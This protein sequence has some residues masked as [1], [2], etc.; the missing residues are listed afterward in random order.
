[1]FYRKLLAALALG[2]LA[3]GLV[4]AVRHPAGG[5]FPLSFPKSSL[6]ARGNPAAPVRV[7]EYLDY[8]CPACVAQSRL[9]EGYAA[10][11]PTR[12]YWEVRFYPFLNHPHAFKSAIYADCAARR[13][14]FWEFHK[15]LFE[16]QAEW[17]ALPRERIDDHLEGL[18]REVGIAPEAMRACVEDPR[19]KEA[20][21]EEVSAAKAAGVRVTP[22]FLV[23]GKWVTTEEDL[24][25][26][27]ER[28]LA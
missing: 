25:K 5:P 9:M 14:R 23:N 4:W 18:A 12:L 16:R 13:G 19:V 1:M 21:L 20:V 3:A 27:L 11:F 28:S 10:R 7:I 24:K 26:E 8:Q 6:R 15:R 17:G 22:T 2:A